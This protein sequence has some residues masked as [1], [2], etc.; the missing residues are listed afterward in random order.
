[1]HYNYNSVTACFSL[2]EP[3]NE[4]ELQGMLERI[5]LLGCQPV[6]K[7]INNEDI[8]IAQESYWCL[9]DIKYAARFRQVHF[10]NAG[11]TTFA[12][13]LVSN[14]FLPVDK[15]LYSPNGDPKFFYYKELLVQLL[16]DLNPKIG[17]IDFD[18]DLICS[19]LKTG[20]QGTI[21]SWGN[22]FPLQWIN[23]LPDE[24]KRN[25]LSVVDES[26]EVNGMGLLTFIHPLKANQ[27][28]GSKHEQ[29]DEIIKRYFVF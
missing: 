13:D 18:A 25:L 2:P 24:V 10:R 12:F 1:M 29:L 15:T 8:W 19:E 20:F 3:L 21:A 23:S 6:G 17:V 7:P 5:K 11:C 14:Y 26:L 9:F 4:I 27:G 16:S 22:Y 28:W